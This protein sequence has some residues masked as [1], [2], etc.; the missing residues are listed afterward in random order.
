MS[1]PKSKQL[2]L[3]QGPQIQVFEFRYRNCDLK[4]KQLNLGSKSLILNSKKWCK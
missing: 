2:N 1:D 4:F 3:G